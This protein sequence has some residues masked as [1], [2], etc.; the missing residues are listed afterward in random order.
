MTRIILVALSAY[1]VLPAL[2]QKVDPAY[3]ILEKAYKALRQQDYE[4]AVTA[5]EQAAK[6]APDRPSIRKDLAYTLIKIGE[7]ARARDQFAEAMRLDPADE[8]VALEYGFLCYETK[9]EVAARRVFLKYRGANATAAEAFENIDRPLRE[10]IARWQQALATSPE[11]FSGHE[12]LAR[13]AEQRD[14]IALA[15][16]HYERAWRLRPQRRDLLLDMG[17]IWKQLDR[18]E[19]SVS[20][21]IAASRGAEPRIAEQARERMG[22]RY[23]YVYEFEKAL[24]LDPSNTGLR[25]ELA[26]LQLQLQQNAQAEKEFVAV[27]ERD[28]D[29]LFVVAQL[30]L[31]RLARGDSKGAMP[32]LNRVLASDNEELADRVRKALEKPQTLRGRAEE[33]RQNISAE[34]REL[35]AKSLEKGYLQDAV[36]YLNAALEND[37]VDFGSMLKLGWTYNQLKNDRAAMRWFKMAASSPDQETST[38]ASRAYRNLAP[39]FE[40]V[41]TTVWMLPMFSTRW[42]DLF[43]YSQ[44]KT[45]WRTSNGWFRPYISLRFIGDARDVVRAAPS[46]APQFYSEQSVIPAVGIASKSWHGASGWFEAGEAIRFRQPPGDATRGKPDYRGGIT[47]AKSFGESSLLAETSDDLVYVHRFNRDTLFYSQ[48]RLGYKGSRAQVYWNFGITTD[49]KREHWANYAETGPGVRFRVASLPFL[50]SVNALR[51]V[52]LDGTGAFNDLRIGLWYAFTK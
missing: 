6:L 32:L 25:R 20:A 12:E 47:Y 27:L 36:K 2:A 28:P 45:E 24:T 40:R 48:N 10:G 51:G 31:L 46:L 43:L 21:L 38:E 42:H 3:P 44:A 18:A 26:F 4:Q 23:P 17:R 8:H 1:L 15:A 49:F 41:R 11:N 39:Q 22:S 16:K 34:A 14:D 13:L 52:H 30:G 37:P 50:F 19:D 33:P 7:N 5:F 29:D 35:A 9:Q